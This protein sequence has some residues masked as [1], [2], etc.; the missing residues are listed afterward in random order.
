MARWH[1]DMNHLAWSC[2]SWATLP[3]SQVGRKDFHPSLLRPQPPA[4]HWPRDR[5]SLVSLTPGARIR[6]SSE[7]CHESLHA[8]LFRYN[9]AAYAMKMS[10]SDIFDVLSY[11]PSISHIRLYASEALASLP[12]WWRLPRP[13]H[14]QTSRQHHHGWG[15]KIQMA[16]NNP[17]IQHHH[18]WEHPSREREMDV[19]VSAAGGGQLLA[20]YHFNQSCGPLI[21]HPGAQMVLLV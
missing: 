16:Q 15:S 1:Q 9:N 2:P 20:I 6:H 12:F 7:S 3:S 19:H 13:W 21:L 17:I 18:L 4:G 14:C 11:T 10:K 8:C 5:M